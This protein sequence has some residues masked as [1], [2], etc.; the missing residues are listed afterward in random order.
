MRL[1]A[2]IERMASPNLD[3]RD[4]AAEEIYVAGSILARRAV[5]AWLKDLEFASLVGAELKLTVG[6]A[7]PRDL[8][9]RIRAANGMPRLADVPADQ[10]AEE[11][12][13]HFP[14]LDFD[15]LTSAA[16]EGNGAI[17]RYLGKFWAG[18]QQVE[19]LCSDVDRATTI[20]RERFGVA[21]IYPKTRA[22]ADGTRVN[23]FLVTTL[24][25]EKVLIELYE[26]TGA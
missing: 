25:N 7:V 4:A 24:E 11:F 19:F 10:D 8:F 26:K 22:G 5:R 15:V 3:E 20:L 14:G 9:A 18:I 6:V 12:E 13:I 16:P 2:Q 21:P 17:A 23:F 1:K